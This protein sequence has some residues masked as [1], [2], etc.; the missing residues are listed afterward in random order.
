M[1][2]QRIL[3]LVQLFILVTLGVFLFWSSLAMLST[4]AQ[5]AVGEWQRADLYGAQ[6]NFENLLISDE[7]DLY[8]C[9]SGVGYEVY[10][11]A[12]GSSQWV[13]MAST[14]DGN[15]SD[16]VIDN[17][18]NLLYRI[19][20]KPDRRLWRSDNEGLSWVSLF[21]PTSPWNF[22][23][24]ALDSTTPTILHVVAKSYSSDQG[25]M[26]RSED[27]GDSWSPVELSMD[28]G[29]T[30]TQV[31]NTLIRKIAVDPT[32]GRYVYIFA[33]GE[34]PSA[35]DGLYRSIDGGQ[36][37]IRLLTSTDS[38]VGV[39]VNMTGTLFA[40]YSGSLWRS[41]DHGDSWQELTDAQAN[42]NDPNADYFGFHPVLT[43][44][45]F[46]GREDGFACRS[47]DEGDTWIQTD[48]D[49]PLMDPTDPSTWFVAHLPGA[50][51]SVN[52]G[53][54]WTE[55][56]TGLA[57]ISIRRIAADRNNPQARYWV[58]AG[59]GVGFT[60]DGG[61]TW[62]FPLY[63]SGDPLPGI[64]AY[65]L[66]GGDVVLH[67]TDPDRVYLVRG[68]QLY[69][70]DSWQPDP[71]EVIDT[72][73]AAPDLE[74]QTMALDL[75]DPLT[76][77]LA[78]SDAGGGVYKTTDGG[79]TWQITSLAGQV[80]SLLLITHTQGISIYAGTFEDD[81]TPGR[82]YRSTNGGDS[83][84]LLKEFD[85]LTVIVMAADPLDPHHLF[86]GTAGDTGTYPDAFLYQSF[87][88][89]ETWQKSSYGQFLAGC[90]DWTADIAIDPRNPKH[91]FMANINNGNIC[92]S[93]TSGQTWEPYF[94]W[95]QQRGIGR[96]QVVHI[97]RQPLNIVGMGGQS[98]IQAT[99]GS[100]Q[101]IFYL[102][103]SNG[104]YSKIL[105]DS[106]YY[107]PVVF[108]DD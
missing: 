41:A 68:N 50:W 47:D 36:T 33:V 53:L 29:T 98:A 1:H 52:A 59:N 4:H 15:C 32:D 8:T 7:G 26:Y 43:R 6:M 9:L 14:G 20:G 2:K 5:G 66:G 105:S 60:Q 107:L 64:D 76:G 65:D 25:R 85:G 16:M 12:K 10:Q 3:R 97:H 23:L 96:A 51:K 61:K 103:T 56:N 91:V 86:A 82:I 104:V 69:R 99:D 74:A 34:D 19:G 80:R 39:A 57:E 84:T 54:D 78:A 75:T 81:G 45:V 108:K 30:Y 24:V 77:Y 49:I 48:H 11:L 27:A 63:I 58:M 31:L 79:D 93:T 42:C 17:V 55:V 13:H 95:A 92:Q 73:S 89:A 94:I 87:D 88:G 38:T 40:S 102:G 22:K 90:G 83:W 71:S 106:Y 44:T 18:N 21:E 70:Y 28:G 46:A 72:N 67:P 101:S 100:T 62:T 35:E 37:Y